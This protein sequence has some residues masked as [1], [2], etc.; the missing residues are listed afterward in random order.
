MEKL[1][2][3]ESLLYPTIHGIGDKFKNSRDA[4]FEKEE[5]DED[6]DV[7]ITDRV[8]GTTK[9]LNFV[10]N[11]GKSN[12]NTIDTGDGKFGFSFYYARY[13]YADPYKLKCPDLASD[14]HNIAYL[15][16]IRRE[17]DEEYPFLVVQAKPEPH[18]KGKLRII[19][20]YYKQD[21]PSILRYLAHLETIMGKDR[22]SARPYPIFEGVT[23]KFLKEMSDY[24]NARHAAFEKAQ[25]NK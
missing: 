21:A 10:W 25:N 13:A 14:K 3:L 24:Y 5:G 9:I 7:E 15:A 20:A 19:T 11:R 22:G 8:S 12:R 2:T 16:R 6:V 4:F 1:I 18:T 23:P 17:D